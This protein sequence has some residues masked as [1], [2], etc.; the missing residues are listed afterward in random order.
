MNKGLYIATLEPHSGKSM[1]I[2]GLMQSLLGKMAKVAYFKPVVA[3]EEEKDNHI[4]TILSHFGLNSSYDESYAVTRDE[5]IRN[6][7]SG[8]I[9]DSLEKSFLNTKN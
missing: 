5:L 4:E 6:R 2:L 3:S 9:A 1:I 7:N 8:K